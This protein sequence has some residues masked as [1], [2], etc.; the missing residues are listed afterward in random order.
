[1][2]PY[3]PALIDPSTRQPPSLLGVG[4]SI[5]L[6]ALAAWIASAVGL[7]IFVG[8]SNF[9]TVWS[10][11]PVSALAI[12][13]M[14]FVAGG[15]GSFVVTQLIARNASTI[16]QLAIAVVG[17]TAFGYAPY[18]TEVLVNRIPA[19]ILVDAEA[20]WDAVPI[21]VA[22]AFYFVAASVFV[23]AITSLAKCLMLRSREEH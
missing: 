21:V 19:S 3:E 22:S 18:L 20:R 1:M 11:Q 6:Y 5:A 9:L 13:T 17:G 14:I 4:A 7:A 10:M 15:V 16:P 12:Q 8:R 2:N 23:V